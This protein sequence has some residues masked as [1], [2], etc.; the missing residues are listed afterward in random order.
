MEK[1]LKHSLSKEIGKRRKGDIPYSV[2]DT[3]KF[4]SYTDWKPE[5]TFD[6][7]MSDLLNYWRELVSKYGNQFL[8]R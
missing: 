7:T 3:T 2:A 1:I 4:K 5:Y 8:Q 6:Q